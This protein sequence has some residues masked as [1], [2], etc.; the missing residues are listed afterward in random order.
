[1][2]SYSQIKNSWITRVIF[3]ITLCVFGIIMDVAFVHIE[4]QPMT[5]MI[6]LLGMIASEEIRGGSYK[7]LGFTFDSYMLRESLFGLLMGI[8][9]SILLI[10]LFA[11]NAWI[12]LKWNSQFEMA[13]I[14]PI[15]SLAIIEELIF[16]GIIFQALV[17]RFGMIT[18]S[19]IFALLF[20]MAHLANPNFEP[21]A[22]LNTFLVSLVFSYSW[23]HTRGLWLP[24]LLH[25]SWNLMLYLMG[26][27]LSGMELKNSLFLTSLSIEIPTPWLNSYYGIE[28]TVFCT[29]ILILFFPIIQMLPQSPI[30]MAELFRLN[31]AINDA[32]SAGEMYED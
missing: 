22:M 16:R 9:P 21:I 12:D 29:I 7:T 17:E 27:T 1:M 2:N 18:I 19:L 14:L 23:Y 10:S 26:M 5:L 8:V 4:G 11:M 13:S 15:I 28:G 24:I 31:Y 25:I 30:R 32:S 20:S 6:L 3:G